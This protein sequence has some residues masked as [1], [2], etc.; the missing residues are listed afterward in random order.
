M[1][2][3]IKSL[4][5][6][7]FGDPVKR[8][9]DRRF[10]TGRG[11]YVDDIVLPGMAH[12]V[13]VRSDLAHAKILSVD[14]E[15]ARE[16]EGVIGILTGA[17][18]AAAGLGDIPCESMPPH[19]VK[20]WIATPFPSLPADRVMAVGDP[21]AMVIAET[22]RQA[23]DAAELVEVDY[24]ELDPV[25][26]L[27]SAIKADAPQLYPD[28]PGNL[29]FDV[30]L[31]DHEATEA[32]FA[33]A[34]CVVELTTRQPRMAHCSL[35]PRGSI[36]VFDPRDGGYTLHT[37]TQNPH[38]VRRLLAEHI[39]RV[40]AHQVR[41]VAEDVGGGF[42]LK[43][44]LYPE[45]V[46]VLWAANKLSRPVKWIAT[47]SEAFL[48]D[49]QARDQ[50]STG[51]L[52]LDG[53]G[54]I[55]AL[56]VLSQTNLGCRL[57]P[58]TGV[59]PFLTARMMA[60]PYVIP[61]AHV[62]AQGVFSNTR[63]TT[64][65]RGAGRPEA[66]YFL[67]R[68]L[69]KAARE[70]SLDPVEIRRR[71]LVP[72]DAMPYA[73]ALVDTYDCGEFGTVLEK[74]IAAA[75]WEGFAARQI[76]S[77]NAGRLRGR[78]LCC[79][80]EVCAIGN[81]RME[82][83][84]DPTGKATVIAG[85]YSHGQG[86]ETVFTQMASDW[87]GLPLADIGFIDGDTG[88][89]SHGG[90]TYASR[91][92]TV[93]GSALR[94]ACD[95]IIEQG[96]SIAAWLLEADAGEIDFEDGVYSVRGTNRTVSLTDAAVASYRPIGYPGHLGAGLEAVGTYSATPQNYP[97]GC[98]VAEV[99]IDRNTGE[100][101]VDRY[102][103]V[104]D[105]GAPAN[106]LL[107]EG[108]LH[109]SVAQGVGQALLERVHYDEAGQQT[110]AAFVDYAMPR[111]EHLP[112]ISSELHLVP[113]KTNPLGVKGGAEVG[114]IGA[115]P[116]IIQAIE[117]ALASTDIDSEIRLPAWPSAVLDALHSASP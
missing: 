17:D 113:T 92:I 3:T 64:S 5:T 74:A 71:N 90:G 19:L 66:T 49:F 62:R 18:F 94:Y 31:G 30:T 82:V 53:D 101:R 85:T 106:P 68:I 76:D 91:S 95:K 75:D 97:N 1:A 4:E 52:A 77:E 24:E 89:V 7:G 54:K 11:R 42:G 100:V 45:D 96:G 15:V 13:F 114:N 22:V 12:A 115:P 103:A 28:A 83:R 67:E 48:A 61:A 41:V 86:H 34:A 88:K 105:V 59:S 40:P 72:A 36:G 55:L 10:V 109:G 87:L 26:S 98:H 37:S 32:A 60:G 47:R 79:F 63:T 65:Y 33:A 57:G 6:G 21:V 39:L 50:L 56:D 58:A 16:G 102:T 23:R 78:G 73:T 108:Q 29:C 46:L 35:E 14:T 38:S 69:D 44:R 84:F 80:V 110:T 25:G 99:E 8:R 27:E 9:E 81:E 20:D 51:R 2:S 112:D 104:D 107:L 43:G 70:L 93:G 116:A 111:A 117:D